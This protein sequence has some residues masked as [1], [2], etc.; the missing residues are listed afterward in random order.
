M[1]VQR[2]TFPRNPQTV[3]VRPINNIITVDSDKTSNVTLINACFITYIL[4]YLQ[5]IH[6]SL[7]G[8]HLLLK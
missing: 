4:F 3:V 5:F 6:I 8:N 7:T 1:R 2:Y